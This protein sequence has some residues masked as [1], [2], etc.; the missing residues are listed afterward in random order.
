MEW[1]GPCIVKGTSFMLLCTAISVLILLIIGFSGTI[2]ITTY[3]CG[4]LRNQLVL[5]AVI[6]GLD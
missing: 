1:S 3:P 6:K 4:H 2:L 5:M